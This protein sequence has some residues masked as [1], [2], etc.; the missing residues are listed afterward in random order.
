MSTGAGL[1]TS[2]TWSIW[3]SGG[4]LPM[5]RIEAVF[6]LRDHSKWSRGVKLNHGK[7]ARAYK[8]FMVGRYGDESAV[9]KAFPNYFPRIKAQRAVLLK[10]DDGTWFPVAT[11]GPNGFLFITEDEA[12]VAVGRLAPEDP[13]VKAPEN[14][15]EAEVV[16]QEE[17][18]RPPGGFEGETITTA[19]AAGEGPLPAAK[20]AT[21]TVASTVGKLAAGAIVAAV[22]RE[23]IDMAINYFSGGRE[24]V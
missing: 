19:A 2:D 3:Q 17:G 16:L 1:P 13:E 15:K 7:A 20:E 12:L 10:A 8:T 9:R 5:E 11:I 22:A 14:P 18:L 6:G 4:G 21:N 24:S 23:G